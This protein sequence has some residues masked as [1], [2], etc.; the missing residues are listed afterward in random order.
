MTSP[1]PSSGS[2]HSKRSSPAAS[3]KH[4]WRNIV[5]SMLLLPGAVLAQSDWSA[6]QDGTAVLFRHANAPGIGDPGNFTLG[7]C[8]TQ[9]NLDATGR[10]QASRIG[11]QF[12]RQRIAVGQVLH[13]QWC[14]TRDTAQLAF[15]GVASDAA[16]FNSFFK[17][18][19]RSEE[20]TASALQVLQRWKGPGVLVVITHQVNIT[21]LTGIFPASGEGLIVKPAPAGLTIVGRVQP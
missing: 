4:H 12:R 13:S 10:T 14:R 7:D 3:G 15:P 9:R 19:A 20:Q 17:E 16:T 21:A 8:A 18:S 2:R 1:E 5:F 11:E 6:L